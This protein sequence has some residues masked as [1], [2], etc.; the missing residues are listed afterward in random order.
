V[1]TV[2]AGLALPTAV[3]FADDGSVF[4]AEREGVIKA[5]DSVADPTLT[6]S[7]SRGRH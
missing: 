7:R 2:F 3:R 5:Y 6:T 1:E 4:V